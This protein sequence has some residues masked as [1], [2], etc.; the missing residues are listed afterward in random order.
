MATVEK[1]I[2]YG[3]AHPLQSLDVHRS[4]RDGAGWIIFIHGGAWRDPKITSDVGEPLLSRL[5]L[6]LSC[7]AASLNYR[8]SPYPNS[9]STSVD[10]ES[11][12]FNAEL[13][14][15]DSDAS[16]SDSELASSDS[17]AAFSDSEAAYSDSE[18]PTSKHKLLIPDSELTSSTLRFATLDLKSVPSHT[19]ALPP[20]TARHPDHINDVLSALEYLHKKYTLSNYVIIGHSAGATL[21][22]QA[23]EAILAGRNLP[24]PKVIM[25]LEGI[26]DIG[27][28]VKEYGDDYRG[29][30]EGAFGQEEEWPPALDVKGYKGLVVLAQSDQDELLSWRQTEDMKERLQETLG[31]GGAVRVVKA[32]GKHDEMLKTQHLADLMVRYIRGVV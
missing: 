21:A 16:F 26:Y 17:E 29:F 24:L 2:R 11:T 9:E 10:L 27:G 8:L 22:C 20:N 19:E 12:S 3:K 23:V 30:V 25:G 1:D 18:I 28:L 32:K 14:A 4:P 13:A 15:S 5:L 7:N 31:T 6:D